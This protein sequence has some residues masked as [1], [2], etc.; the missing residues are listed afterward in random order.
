M[1][2]VVARLGVGS[3]ITP[4]AAS[5]TPKEEALMDDPLDS[6][7]KSIEDLDLP[8]MVQ[9][10][11]RKGD[12]AEKKQR[13]LRSKRPRTLK[14]MRETDFLASRRETESTTVD[15]IGRILF[16]MRNGTPAD[17]T[18]EKDWAWCQLV[19]NKLRSKGQWRLG[20]QRTS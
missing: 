13:L 14:R 17:E 4:A 15:R 1:D 12:E 3:Q 7:L 9:A 19:A 11:K 16:F 5:G 10:L 8:E 6:F 18:T 2:F 20:A